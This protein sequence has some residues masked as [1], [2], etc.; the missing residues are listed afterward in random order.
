VARRPLK[1]TIR[2]PQY[3]SPRYGWR[4]AIHRAVVEEQRTTPIVY[5]NGDRLELVVRLYFGHTGKASINDVDNRLKDCL[6]ALQGRVG[7]SKRDSR[8]KYPPIIPDDRQIWRVVVEKSVAPRQAK[9]R[10]HLTIRRLKRA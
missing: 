6:D 8:S 3:K 2:I 1:L 5:D 10:G 7:G 4:K 9:G